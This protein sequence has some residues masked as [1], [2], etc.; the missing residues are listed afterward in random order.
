MAQ[1]D[2]LN[3]ET[4]SGIGTTHSTHGIAIQEHSGIKNEH[5]IE[6]SSM[7]RSKRRSIQYTERIGSMFHASEI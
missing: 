6:S 4:P 3:E 5:P 1:N 2:D 7:N